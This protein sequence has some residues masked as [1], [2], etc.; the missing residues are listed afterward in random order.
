MAG[1]YIVLF[2][3]VFIPVILLSLAVVILLIIG[4][5]KKNDKQ[6]RICGTIILTLP[7]FLYWIMLYSFLAGTLKIQFK[8][9]GISAFLILVT[10]VTLSLML[11]WRKKKK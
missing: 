6:K 1:F 9:A 10:I 5:I 3:F 2:N 11:I 4:F 7:G 8:L